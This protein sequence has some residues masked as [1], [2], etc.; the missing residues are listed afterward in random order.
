MEYLTAYFS[1][2]YAIIKCMNN[3]WIIEKQGNFKNSESSTSLYKNNYISIMF[4]S[5]VFEFKSNVFVKPD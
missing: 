2:T 4:I 3:A 1:L 5:G